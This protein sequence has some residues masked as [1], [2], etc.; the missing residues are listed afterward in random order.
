MMRI[1]G[2]EPRGWQAARCNLL[3]LLSPYYVSSWL[4]EAVDQCMHYQVALPTRAQQPA[5][6]FG[7][8]P[9]CRLHCCRASAP[10]APLCRI[11]LAQMTQLDAAFVKRFLEERAAAEAAAIT[12]PAAAAEPPGGG[13]TRSGDG[14]QGQQAAAAAA[15]EGE[16]VPGDAAPLLEGKPASFGQQCKGGTEAEWESGIVPF[17]LPPERMPAP[18]SGG[19]AQGS[20]WAVQWGAVFAGPCWASNCVHILPWQTHALVANCSN[21]NG[22]PTAPVLHSRRPQ[23]SWAA[24]RQPARPARPCA[25]VRWDGRRQGSRCGCR[26]SSTPCC[27]KP[28]GLYPP[29]K[30]VDVC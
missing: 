18:Y 28:R 27:S 14:G 8:R 5:A 22:P 4:F 3:K 13:G 12:A 7:A 9:P 23:P 16:H 2:F 19:R 24:A 1:V 25:I 11:L 30:R 21:P 15:G 26:L 29:S 6:L 17:W 20:W 10:H